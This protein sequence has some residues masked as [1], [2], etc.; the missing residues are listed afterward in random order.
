MA[1]GG[2]KAVVEVL[3]VTGGVVAERDRPARGR[4]RGAADALGLL[5]QPPE[6]PPPRAQPA[7]AGVAGQDE[8]RTPDDGCCAAVLVRLWPRSGGGGR[9]RGHGHAPRQVDGAGW[10]GQVSSAHAHAFCSV[11]RETGEWERW[12]G[13][14][15]SGYM[16]LWRS[17]LM[18]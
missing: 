13:W 2:A 8:L 18:V 3:G 15:S 17:G 11:A 7:P 14:S 4:R 5:R 10:R 1:A 9:G 12:G 6:Q 16:E